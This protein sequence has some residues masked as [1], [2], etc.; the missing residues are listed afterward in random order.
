[1]KKIKLLITV[2]LL[3]LTASAFTNRFGLDSYDIYLNNKLVQK[4]YVNQ[5]L[6]SRVLALTKATE[7]DQLQITYTHCMNKGTGTARSITLKDE[8]GTSL[9]KWQFA[10][11]KSAKMAVPVK[12]LLHWQKKK[13]GH[14]LSL[15]YTAKESEKEEM[16]S[17]IR[18]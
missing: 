3:T 17:K 7:S 10:D 5:P 18:F 9:F 2:I 16:L 6:S 1:M 13:A 8:K 12:E 11:G 15:Y 4:Y 14:E